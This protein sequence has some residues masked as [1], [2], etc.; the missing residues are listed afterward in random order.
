MPLTNARNPLSSHEISME[1]RHHVTTLIHLVS[2]EDLNNDLADK[3]LNLVLP[4]SVSQMFFICEI[5]QVE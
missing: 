1:R 5:S 4:W 2:R 3:H